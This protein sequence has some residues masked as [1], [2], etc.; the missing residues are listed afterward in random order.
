MNPGRS[1]PE[2]GP[3][4]SPDP[5][6]VALFVSRFRLPRMAVDLNLPLTAIAAFVPALVDPARGYPPAGSVVYMDGTVDPASIGPATAVLR[7]T[8]ATTIGGVRI[9]P[10][11]ADPA[12]GIWIVL[13]EAAH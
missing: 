9:V 12:A 10:L 5:A 2:P 8:T 1:T 6:T 3:L 7:V 4:G 11:R 13:V